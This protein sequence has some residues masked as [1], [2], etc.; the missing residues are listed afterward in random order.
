[1]TAIV[2]TRTQLTATMI[3]AGDFTSLESSCPGAVARSLNA[4]IASDSFT[5]A[6]LTGPPATVGIGMTAVDASREGGGKPGARAVGGGDVD[7]PRA[8]WTTSR[9]RQ[10][11]PSTIARASGETKP[12]RTSALSCSSV[13]CRMAPLYS[14]TIVSITST[15]PQKDPAILESRL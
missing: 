7:E 14:T 3:S 2:R 11:S 6:A 9:T 13:T 4:I 8:D 5:S 12:R 10:S 15:P 1:M